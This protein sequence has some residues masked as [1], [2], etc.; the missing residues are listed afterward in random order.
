MQGYW[1]FIL[2][3]SSSAVGHGC[4]MCQA[5]SGAYVNDVKGVYTNASGHIVDCSKLI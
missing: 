5:Y 3:Y 2:H 4:E 1:I